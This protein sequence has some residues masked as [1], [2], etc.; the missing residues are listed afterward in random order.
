MWNSILELQKKHSLPTLNL[1]SNPSGT[2][3]LL[4]CHVLLFTIMNPFM[5]IDNVILY[6]LKKFSIGSIGD[7]KENPTLRK[8]YIRL[9]EDLMSRY[10]IE[11][12][13][14]TNGT[15]LDVPHN[16]KHQIPLFL[17]IF[18]EIYESPLLSRIDRDQDNNIT[19]SNIDEI[20][21]IDDD[22]VEEWKLKKEKR[23]K[24]LKE[25][26]DKFGNFL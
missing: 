20:Q 19:F 3:S 8:C 26:Y 24:A 21:D 23:L 5:S 22:M 9:T 15:F 1:S 4:S 25:N 16:I 10:F 18:K 17:D 2:C 13:H 7:Y 12:L 6:I 14:E 11:L